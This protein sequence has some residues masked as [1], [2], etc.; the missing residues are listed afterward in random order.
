MADLTTILSECK[1]LLADDGSLFNDQLITEAVRQTLRTMNEAAGFRRIGTVTI[2]AAAWEFSVSTLTQPALIERIWLP[3]R[4]DDVI[5]RWR[6]FELWPNNVVRI[7]EG[8]MPQVN[9]VARIWYTTP[10]TLTGLDAAATTTLDEP[11][12]SALVNGAAAFSIDSRIRTTAEA[13]KIDPGTGLNLAGLRK[14][15]AAR[16]DMWLDRQ[17]NKAAGAFLPWPATISTRR[18]R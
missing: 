16:L 9:D 11:A 4:S 17:R 14:R 7:A 3:Y 12:I 18:T 6:T 15:F 2:A 10:H 13:F 5:P 8:D 1:T